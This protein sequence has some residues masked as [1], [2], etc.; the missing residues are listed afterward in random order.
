[1]RKSATFFLLSVLLIIINQQI[2]AQMLNSDSMKTE[3]NNSALDKNSNS[4][5][6][7]GTF[8]ITP[9]YQYCSFGNIE[10]SS[11]SGKYTFP[12]KIV[13]NDFGEEEINDYNNNY[14]SAYNYSM[15]ALMIGYQLTEGFGISV[16]G[17]VKHLNFESWISEDN[18]HNMVSEYPSFTSGISADYLL[19]IKNSFY[20][21]ALLS[22]NFTTSSSISVNSDMSEE[23]LKSH[24]KSSFC[25]ANLALAYKT[26]RFTPYLGMGYTLQFVHPVYTEQ[27]TTNDEDGIPFTV[28]VEFDSQYRGDAIYGFAGVDYLL[29]PKITFFARGAFF[30]LNRLSFGIKLTI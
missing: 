19:K 4:K 16:Y 17:G 8:F 7:K 6:H 3:I 15:A 10:M 11:L 22:Y 26:G 27:Y 5:T 28:D 30:E 1:M 21:V 14:G 18:N 9:F 23:V 25:E 29:S 13:L 2:N 12:D 20:A 24:I